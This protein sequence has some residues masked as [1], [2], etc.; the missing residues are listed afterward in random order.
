[1]RDHGPASAVRAVDR[2]RILPRVP[3]DHRGNVISRSVTLWPRVDTHLHSH[4]RRGRMANIAASVASTAASVTCRRNRIPGG[5][6]VHLAHGEPAAVDQF[7]MVSG[8]HRARYG[9]VSGRDS[10]HG[11][12]HWRISGRRGRTRVAAT[13]SAVLL[14]DSPRRAA[15][16][17]CFTRHASVSLGRLWRRGRY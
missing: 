2:G 12:S 4:V 17:A 13:G 1:M 11:A 3:A 10:C 9:D 16:S 14:V 15:C 5:N 7:T 8:A 6:G